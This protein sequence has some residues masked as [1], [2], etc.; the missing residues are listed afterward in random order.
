M[1]ISLSSARSVSPLYSEVQP[2]AMH[3]TADVL[4]NYIN[5]TKVQS[6]AF[7]VLG[8]LLASF[9]TSCVLKLKEDANGKQ[10]Q[11][12]DCRF[13]SRSS[14]TNGGWHFH[15]FATTSILAVQQ[16]V[17]T[18]AAQLKMARKTISMTCRSFPNHLP[19][20]MSELP[21]LTC[22]RRAFPRLFLRKSNLPICCLKC[23][24]AHPVFSP[25]FH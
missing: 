25:G 6:K 10:P 2:I 18:S 3:L 12:N 13:S 23:P 5:F 24:K 4:D 8:T 20:F 16:R 11:G 9:A 7:M 14:F 1:L 21:L 19:R 17:L 22:F 15:T